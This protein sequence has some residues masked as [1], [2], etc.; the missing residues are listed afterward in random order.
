MDCSIH[1]FNMYLQ[2]GYIFSITGKDN[3]VTVECYRFTIGRC[4]AYYTGLRQFWPVPLLTT[5]SWVCELWKIKFYFISFYVH[6]SP[7]INHPNCWTSIYM[8]YHFLIEFHNS[9][10]NY[11]YKSNFEHRNI[12]QIPKHQLN[13]IASD[14]LLCTTFKLIITNIS[15]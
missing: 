6:W 8:K 10:Q 13:I 15:P 9:V 3:S 11:I 2:L 7:I 1:L 12:G 5:T 14:V 4:G